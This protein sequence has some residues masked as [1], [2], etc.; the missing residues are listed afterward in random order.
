[1]SKGRYNGLA[2]SHIYGHLSALVNSLSSSGYSIDARPFIAF[3]Q[4]L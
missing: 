4:A 3:A 2:P 1:M